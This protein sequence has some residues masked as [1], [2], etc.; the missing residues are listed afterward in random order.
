MSGPAD[1]A[2]LLDKE[3]QRAKREAKP[4]ETSE[5]RARRLALNNWRSNTSSIWHNAH[6]MTDDE[7]IWFV[8]LRDAIKA[9][10]ARKSAEDALRLR[11]LRDRLF[12]RWCEESRR[13]YR[14]QWR[15]VRDRLQRLGLPLPPNAYFYLANDN[16]DRG[17]P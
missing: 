12:E 13:Q 10:R 7:L 6:L 5:R 15:S 16:N 3:R 2:A 11:D 17:A 9:K 14:E 4:K 8:K 1:L